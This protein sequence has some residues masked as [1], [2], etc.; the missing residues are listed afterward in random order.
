MAYSIARLTLY[1]LLT[2][3]DSD[4]RDAI[5]HNL[6]SN[7]NVSELLPEKIS[8][9]RGTEWSGTGDLTLI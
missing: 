6:S 3:V 7:H 9:V 2:A 5:I 4:F 1:A 8:S